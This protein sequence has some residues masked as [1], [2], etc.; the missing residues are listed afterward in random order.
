MIPS[1]E[2]VNSLK[3]L[4][5][6]NL[7]FAAMGAQCDIWRSTRQDK[8]V[9][10]F[11]QKYRQMNATAVGFG[12]PWSKIEIEK[13]DYDFS[14]IDWFLERTEYVGLKLVLMLF[15]SNVCGTCQVTSDG[16]VYPRFTADYI[17]ENPEMYTQIL[18]NTNTEYDHGGPPMCPND[19]DTLDRESLYVERLASYLKKRD[20]NRTTI[21][22]QIN[23]EYFYQRWLKPSDNRRQDVRC[24]CKY[25]RKKYSPGRF[26]S[27]EEFMY[28]SFAEYTAVLSTKIK[29]IYPLPLYVNSPWW[30]PYIIE[31]FLETCPDIDFV[32]IDGISDPNEPNQ[33]TVGQVSRNIP[34]AAECPTEAPTTKPFLTALP[35]YTLLKVHSFGMFL[36]EAPE[37]NTLV[38]DDE[39]LLRFSNALYPIKNAI[40]PLIETR[41]SDRLLVWYSQSIE[42]TVNYRI[43]ILGNLVE[44][45]ESQSLENQGTRV[46]RG[47]DVRIVKDGEF[48]LPFLDTRLK[49]RGSQA[50][51][52]IVESEGG[53]VLGTPGAEIDFIDRDP[54]II[55]SGVYHSRRWKK[56]DEF[57]VRDGHASLSGLF[58]IRY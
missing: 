41:G 29:E 45:D 23:N 2:L 49:I 15:N 1:I 55:E 16:V 54:R 37:P 40:V 18:L 51:F 46:V 53:F 33:L 58:Y 9:D 11:L 48:V 42:A 19:P 36:W 26:K 17:L 8:E 12:I 34:F 21:M 39:A 50:G 5:V 28:R 22:L 4:V 56:M 3:T 35:Y 7:P 30:R 38:Y 57:A 43:D 6:D 27:G 25:C 14:F 52:I 32:G 13:D 31:I 44:L 24:I 10:Y 47:A 20:V